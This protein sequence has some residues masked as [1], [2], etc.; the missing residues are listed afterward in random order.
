MSGRWRLGGGN[1]VLVPAQNAEALADAL[2]SLLA[3]ST[4]HRAAMGNASRALAQSRFD[5][6]LVNA[7]IFRALQISARSA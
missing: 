5:A 1:G 2:L 4:E 3:T 7:I 6:D